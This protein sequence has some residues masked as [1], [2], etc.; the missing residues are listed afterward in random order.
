MRFLSALTR[1]TTIKG[2]EKM[3]NL[4]TSIVGMAVLCCVTPVLAGPPP[5]VPA[6]DIVFLNEHGQLQTGVRC[7]APPLN[8]KARAAVE[9]AL[10][11]LHKNGRPTPPPT[12]TPGPGPEPSP[13]VGISVFFH[14]IYTTGRGGV[15]EGK[16]PLHQLET[17]IDVLNDAYQETGF[18]FHLGGV[19]YTENKQWFTGCY[20]GAE[21]AMKQS[22][23]VNPATTLNI[24]TCKPRNSILGYSYLPSSFPEDHYAHG[25][26]VLYSSLPGG[27]AAPY[28]LGDTATHE[29]G[30]YLG[31][32]HTFDGGCSLPGD[33]VADTP[34]EASPAFGCPHDRDTCIAPGLDPIYNFMD[35]TDD[36]C[37]VEFTY[38]QSDRMSDLV[39]LYKPTLAALLGP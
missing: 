22:L 30:H 20:G 5:N 31:L 24:Y 12:P 28:N 11:R 33:S 16:V 8:P 37:M 4:L 2:V 19:D 18:A 29:V 27:T 25:V 35:Y 32:Y 21:V 15:T 26:V 34:A 1:I 3:K 39:T 6:A 17:Q 10:A 36:E 23:A 13:G 9:A 14:V 7:A 38:G